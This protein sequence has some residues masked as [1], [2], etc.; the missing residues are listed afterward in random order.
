MFIWQTSIFCHEYNMIIGRYETLFL[1]KK[2]YYF[3][4][5]STIFCHFQR[6]N[7]YKMSVMTLKDVQ[8][9][10]K[11]INCKRGARAE[12][13]WNPIKFIL[14][15]YLDD[16]FWIAKL[17]IMTTVFLT[18][19][20]MWRNICK[21]PVSTEYFPSLLWQSRKLFVF[22]IFVFSHDIFIKDNWMM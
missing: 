6:K 7:W 22:F 19:L 4:Q 10:K 8:I 1:I 3:S 16:I 18:D 5:P 9:W 15:K 20:K 12:K 13:S 21:F 14:W 11:I 2:V 17:F